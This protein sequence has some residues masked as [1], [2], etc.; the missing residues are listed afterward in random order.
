V[1]EQE[2]I[3]R[4]GVFGIDAEIDAVCLR[5]GSWGKAVS[6]YDTKI[7]QLHHRFTAA[8]GSAALRAE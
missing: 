5:R 1:I 2:Q 6:F 8:T 3:D 4:R 7:R